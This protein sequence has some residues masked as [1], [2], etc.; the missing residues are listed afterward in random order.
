MR[1]KL[2]VAYFS[3]GRQLEVRRQP[4]EARVAYESAVAID[5]NR[6]EAQGRLALVRPVRRAI[7]W[8]HYG[9][10]GPPSSVLDRP[11]LR[12]FPEGDTYVLES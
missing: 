10:Q 6:P 8:D 3:R 4:V 12:L 7:V 1:D 5:P 9:W 2:Y 11:N